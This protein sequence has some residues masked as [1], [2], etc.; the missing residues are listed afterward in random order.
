MFSIERVLSGA[1]GRQKNRIKKIEREP[2]RKFGF[3]K[4]GG[5][6]KEKKNPKN[7]GRRPRR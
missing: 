1:D 3:F 2:W 4:G 6:R 7:V 5:L